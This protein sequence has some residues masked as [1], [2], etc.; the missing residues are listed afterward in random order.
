MHCLRIPFAAC[1]SDHL[2]LTASHYRFGSGN[3]VGAV[4]AGMHSNTHPYAIPL[5]ALGGGIAGSIIGRPYT[6]WQP[7]R[8]P[9]T[10]PACV[11]RS[12]L[13]A[14]SEPT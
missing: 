13:S 6:A 8:P 10:D 9:D 4:I 3:S 1:R 11:F 5:Y 2:R 14:D 12:K 7:T